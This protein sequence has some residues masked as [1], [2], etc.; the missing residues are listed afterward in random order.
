MET[1]ITQIDVKFIHAN[2]DHSYKSDESIMKRGW[3]M[4]VESVMRLD[5]KE[6][7]QRYDASYVIQM[8]K[9]LKM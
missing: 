6:I 7:Q 5:S 4:R 8:V 3:I 1:I 9:W 2:E